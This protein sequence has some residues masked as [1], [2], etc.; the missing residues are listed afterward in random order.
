MTAPRPGVGPGRRRPAGPDDVP[1]RRGTPARII[2]RFPADLTA[3]HDS[4]RG[5]ARDV[6]DALVTALRERLLER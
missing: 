4:V 6:D 5:Y 3:A 2:E 1:G